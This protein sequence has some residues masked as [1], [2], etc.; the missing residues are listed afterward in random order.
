VWEMGGN[1]FPSQ[2]QDNSMGHTLLPRVYPEG[3]DIFSPSDPRDVAI[4]GES[5]GSTY[6]KHCGSPY[7][8]WIP[9]YTGRGLSQVTP[10]PGEHLP[11]VQVTTI[12]V[13]GFDFL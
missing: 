13:S 11:Q 1:S 2:P 12:T 5:L 4:H 8:C 6:L 3:A 9:T 7:P 10:I